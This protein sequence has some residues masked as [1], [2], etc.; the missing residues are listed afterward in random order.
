M[1]PKTA[2]TAF[3]Q[4]ETVKDNILSLINGSKPNKIYS[5]QT[6]I[7]GAIKLTLGKVYDPH[8]YRCFRG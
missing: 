7:E 5:P 1:G 2:R 4:A 8:S 6:E 3:V